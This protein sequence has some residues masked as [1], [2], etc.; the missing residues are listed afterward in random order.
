MNRDSQVKVEIFN[1]SGIHS[2]SETANCYKCLLTVQLNSRFIPVKTQDFIAFMVSEH[3]KGCLW[4]H[5]LSN[6]D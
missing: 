6:M 4:W 3:P 5:S 2:G 1:P